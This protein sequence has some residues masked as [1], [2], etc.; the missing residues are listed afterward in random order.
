VAA[1]ACLLAFAANG[2]AEGSDA[3]VRD[4]LLRDVAS[5]S[6][7]VRDQAAARL[8]S[9]PD[10]T[11][12]ELAA[13]LRT[14]P[15]RA[16]P[17]LLRIASARK[18][19]ALV[20]DIARHASGRDVVAAEA[21]ICALVGLGAEGVE[22]GRAE[23]GAAD[24]SRLATTERD[25]RLRHLRAL[26]VQRRVEQELLTRWRRKG[27]SYRGRYRALEPFGWDAQPVLLAI[28][29]DVPL[30][31]GFIVVPVTGDPE[32]DR[33]RRA[34][35]LTSIALSRRRGYRTFTQL[36]VHIEEE[37][38]FDLAQQAL[39]DVADL[40]LMG[41][42]LR[43]THEQLLRADLDA[44][45]RPR[46]WEEAFAHDIEI[47]LA[48][49]GDPRLLEQRYEEKRSGVT[50]LRRMLQRRDPDESPEE[51]QYYSVQ[52]G[53]LA[54][55]LHQLDRFL[56]A[57]ERYAEVVQIGKVLTGKE[58]TLAGYNRACALSQAGRIDDAFAQLARA[59]D[60]AVSSGVEDLTKEWVTEDGDLEP[61]RSDPRYAAIVRKRFGE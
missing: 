9:N 18:L 39:T 51:Y 32:A 34:S 35:A 21:A 41:D 14:A 23:L 12:E 22:A 52:L 24:A 59:L 60:P 42:I 57:A 61:L 19:T 47:I 7:T 46:K 49:R 58:P 44:G 48:S 25:A 27:G 40:D 54:A 20:P 56:E 15:P 8:E 13:A 10:L 2:R 30:E 38:L 31:D 1:L 50:R 45:W 53:E 37:E 43:D 55:L 11:A 29:L 3:T 17:A 28:L 36:P 26:D 6:A 4:R 5:E 33:M 16:V